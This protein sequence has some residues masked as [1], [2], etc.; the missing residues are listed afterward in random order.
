MLFYLLLGN[1]PWR[2]LSNAYK[3]TTVACMARI[4]IAKERVSGAQLAK[5]HHLPSEF[6]TVLD[7]VRRLKFDENPDYAGYHKL[8]RDVQDRHRFSGS[9]LDWTPEPSAF[10]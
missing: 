9:S 5:E 8:F 7:Q 6:G 10:P 2:K 4:G 3:G 1:L